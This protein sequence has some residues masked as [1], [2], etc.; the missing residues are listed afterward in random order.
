MQGV[1]SYQRQW[2][3]PLIFIAGFND[4]VAWNTNLDFLASPSMRPIT[5]VIQYRVCKIS[6]EKII[7][8]IFYLTPEKNIFCSQCLQG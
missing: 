8:S 1:F 3:A 2:D 7:V 4:S 5:K 6:L